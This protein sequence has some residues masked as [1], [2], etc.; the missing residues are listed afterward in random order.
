MGQTAGARASSDVET[1]GSLIE[2]QS[3]EQLIVTQADA[4]VETDVRLRHSRAF[5]FVKLIPAPSAVVLS[6]RSILG[7]P[8]GSSPPSRV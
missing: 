4:V 8:D 7:K 3:T 5:A 2:W 1:M 6:I